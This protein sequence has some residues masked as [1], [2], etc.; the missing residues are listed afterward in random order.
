M[1]IIFKQV[2]RLLRKVLFSFFQPVLIKRRNEMGESIINDEKQNPNTEGLSILNLTSISNSMGVVANNSFE[3]FFIAIPDKY[4]DQLK[5]YKFI[6]NGESETTSKYY[7]KLSD[8]LIKS[9]NF[10]PENVYNFIST[11]AESVAKQ[12]LEDLKEGR[13]KSNNMMFGVDKISNIGHVLELHL[14]VTDYFSYTCMNRIYRHLKKNFPDNN[15][16]QIKKIDDVNSNSSL[17]FPGP[18]LPWQ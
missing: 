8:F 7:T 1:D 6:K 3:R 11:H 18:K 15:S 5:N 13:Q 4:G 12:F 14:F 17:N 16:L 9:Y 2:V 10:S